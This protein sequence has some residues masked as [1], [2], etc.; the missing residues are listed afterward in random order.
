MGTV[1]SRPELPINPEVS[2]ESAAGAQVNT[3][4]PEW[5]EGVEPGF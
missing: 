3:I 1:E 5:P 2:A 4:S